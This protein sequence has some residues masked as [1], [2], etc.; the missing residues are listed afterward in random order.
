[1]SISLENHIIKMTSKYL[2]LNII[3]IDQMVINS[4]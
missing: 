1:M 3:I 2:F 4:Y